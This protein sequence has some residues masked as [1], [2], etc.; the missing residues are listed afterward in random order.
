M[1]ARGTR[2]RDHS[3][4]VQQKRSLFELASQLL[5]AV[6]GAPYR[7]LVTKQAEEEEVSGAKNAVATGVTVVATAAQL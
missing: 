1:R 3:Q 7:Y 4:N 2:E 6:N 5:G